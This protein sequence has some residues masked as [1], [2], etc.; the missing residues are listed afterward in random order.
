MKRIIILAV[1]L[2][3][4]IITAAASART[5]VSGGLKQT[6]VQS[7]DEANQIDVTPHQIGACFSVYTVGS[8]AYVNAA[9]G[10]QR[11]YRQ[12]GLC[13]IEVRDGAPLHEWQ[14]SQGLLRHESSSSG[15]RY[16]L[17]FDQ[18]EL[19]QLRHLGIPLAVFENLVGTKP[20]NYPFI[21]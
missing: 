10:R 20:P 5:P 17:T 15:W 4:L 3:A 12:G 6:V 14:P 13:D 16:L 11:W 21:P 18:I 1:S 2:S 9:T 19:S 8:L 7:F